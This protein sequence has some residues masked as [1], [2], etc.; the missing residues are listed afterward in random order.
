[1]REGE[2]ASQIEVMRDSLPQADAPT[3]DKPLMPFSTALEISR[4]QENALVEHALE[5]ILQIEEQLGATVSDDSAE[6]T[7]SADPESFFGKRQKFTAQY[8]NHVKWREQPDTIY[9]Q[10]NV[11]ASLSQ[12]I[13]MQM[14]ARA[15]A[16]FFGPPD[17]NDWFHAEGIGIEDEELG[18][19]VK[20]FARWKA[21]KCEVKPRMVESL[22]WAFV[23]GEAVVK[24]T[25]QEKSQIFKR[26]ETVLVGE[27][28]QPMLD[29]YGD[30]ITQNDAWVGEMQEVQMAQPSTMPPEQ[31][32][33]SGEPQPWQQEQPQVA[34]VPTGRMLLKRDQQTIL[35][36]NPIWKT[37][38]ITRKRVTWEGPDVSLVYYQDFLCPINARSIQE[39][40]LICHRYDMPVMGIAQMFNGQFAEGDAGIADLAAAVNILNTLLD[41]P[42]KHRAALDQPRL[43]MKEVDTDTATDDPTAHIC[44]CWLTYDVDGDGI[45]EEIMLILDRESRTPI[46]YE[47]AANVTVRGLRPFEILRPIKVDGRWYGMGSM[48]LFDPEQT[49]IDLQLCRKNMAESGAGCVTFWNP[50]ATV[51][52]QRNPNLKLNHGETYTLVDGKTAKDVIHREYLR[53]DMQDFMELA[54]LFI[55]F[56]QLKSGVV[57][58]ADQESS[59]LPTSDTATGIN[60]IRE[61][62]QELFS[63]MLSRLLPG[64]QGT[65]LAVV[66]IIFAKLNRRESFTYFNG[67]DYELLELSPDDV[68]ELALN[69]RLSVTKQ[70][71][72]Q[73]LQA[74]AQ[75]DALIDK[76][77][78]RPLLL[79][80]RTEKFTRDQLKALRVTRP[81]QIIEPVDPMI[82]MGQ[83]AAGPGQAPVP[84]AEAQNPTPGELM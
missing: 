6:F 78:G 66:D 37:E 50:R 71:D 52:G 24:T 60:E 51:E 28:G 19:K 15:S 47:Y 35:P 33:N 58:A 10:S 31:I 39:A 49:F 36:P 9:E 69:I 55:Q 83:P 76:F 27:D 7:V 84:G 32:G 70:R 75:A 30:F 48:E 42:N 64:V 68:R 43:D 3:E 18:K 61:S 22:E 17:D 21:E 16:F 65:L 82:L 34:L 40:D 62:G 5:R 26:T 23:R 41:K 8:H 56:M 46:Y 67:E 72:R 77:Y 11:T 53:N 79:Q 1:M 38:K 44:E 54:Q 80:E 29:A 45:Q 63:L 14:I 25:H 20:K 12:R 4:D 2:G 74:G 13:T 81:E 57:N 73:I 59:G